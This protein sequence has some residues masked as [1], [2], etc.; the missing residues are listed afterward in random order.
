MKN[1]YR[2]ENAKLTDHTLT[3][4]YVDNVPC[5]S[6]EYHGDNSYTK[7][8]F[9]YDLASIDEFD[10]DVYTYKRGSYGGE[11]SNWSD[12]VRLVWCNFDLSNISGG[13]LLI[14]YNIAFDNGFID[15]HRF[16]YSKADNK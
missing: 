11:G 9:F 7:N 4:R 12:D 1:I 15:N 14:S 5:L 13:E 8:V 3:L 16:R 10:Y 6:R 2:G